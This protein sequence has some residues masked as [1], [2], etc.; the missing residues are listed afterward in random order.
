MQKEMIIEGVRVAEE[1]LKD[2][3]FPD[4]Q[5]MVAQTEKIKKNNGRAE[6]DRKRVWYEDKCQKK[7]NNVGVKLE[8]NEKKV[9]QSTYR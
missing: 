9:I 1:L 3:K 4:D 7:Q 2:V 6:Q 5:L 8:T